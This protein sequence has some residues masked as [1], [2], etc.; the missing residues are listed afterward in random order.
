[1]STVQILTLVT[2][3]SG[4]G[5]GHSAVVVGQTVFTFQD[6]F[7]GWLDKR[8]GWVIDSLSSY[9]RANEHRPALLQTLSKAN[10]KSVVKYVNRSIANDDDYLGSGVCSQQVALA[11]NYA[12]PKNIIFDPKGFDTPFGVFYCAR[13]LALVTSETYS[14]PGRGKLGASVETRIVNKLKSDYPGVLKKI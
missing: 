6:A 13:R 2:N 12:L 1:M 7:N 4:S 8:S 11:V 9:L 14:W 5:P 3:V 10:P